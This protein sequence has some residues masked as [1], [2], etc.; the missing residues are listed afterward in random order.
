MGKIAIVCG[1][2]AYFKP[3]QA[4]NGE[5]RFAPPTPI[6]IGMQQ[7]NA[8]HVR[9]PQAAPIVAGFFAPTQAQNWCGCHRA[10]VPVG[11]APD[12]GAPAEYTT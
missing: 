10:Q 11:T 1:N 2:C 5:C 3:T 6:L 9:G 4:E 12:A 7:V 8:L